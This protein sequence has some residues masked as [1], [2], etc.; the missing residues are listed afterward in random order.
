[1]VASAQVPG[2]EKKKKLKQ[3]L[4]C[5]CFLFSVTPAPLVLRRQHIACKRLVP[6]VIEARAADAEGIAYQLLT[7]I[8]FKSEIGSSKMC[9]PFL[10]LEGGSL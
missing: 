2:A 7:S 9:C 6:E 3:C 5:I 10:P 4:L 8:C 1:M